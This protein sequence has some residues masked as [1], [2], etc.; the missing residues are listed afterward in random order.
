[1]NNKV[2]EDGQFETVFLF[3]IEPNEL[4]SPCNKQK[5]HKTHVGIVA[6]FKK[7]HMYCFPLRDKMIFFQILLFLALRKLHSGRVYAKL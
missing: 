5:K 4:F 3:V 1:M 6:N 7:N 2:L